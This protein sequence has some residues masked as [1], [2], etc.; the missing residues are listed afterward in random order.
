M[1]ANVPHGHS[2]LRLRY[3]SSGYETC[4]EPG[5][6]T[7]WGQLFGLRGGRWA[8]LQSQLLT[9]RVQI[10]SAIAP[11]RTASQLAIPATLKT[12]DGTLLIFREPT[13]PCSSVLPGSISYG[14]AHAPSGAT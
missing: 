7:M 14:L 8:N 3:S 9:L 11:R 10:P 6:Y 2:I 5:R 12:S 1:A 4:H 13:G